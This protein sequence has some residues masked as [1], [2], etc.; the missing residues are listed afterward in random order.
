MQLSVILCAHNPRAE[1]L[2]RTLSSLRWQTVNA[3]RWDFV[4][5]DNASAKPLVSGGVKKLPEACNQGLEPEEVDLSWHPN[6]L[7]VRE[8]ELGL[9]P[10]RLRGIRESAGKVLVFVDDDNVLDADYL[11]QVCRIAGAYPHIGAWGGSCRGEF[12][13][14]PP[15]WLVPYLPG[16][17]VD[18][19]DRDYWSNLGSYGKASPYGAGLCVRSEVAQEF[20]RQVARRPNLKRLD[21][22]GEQLLSGGDTELANC[23][24]QL[25]LGTGRFSSLKLTHLIPK[26]RLTEDY[27]VKLYAGFEVSAAI[28]GQGTAQQKC[29][30]WSKW[31]R[32]LSWV[33]KWI[34]A[35]SLDR[36]IMCEVLRQM[37]KAGARSSKR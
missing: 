6:A 13:E 2:S 16:L 37:S 15:P 25:G 5:V 12:E 9:T 35:S 4:L 26:G 11:E 3:G 33:R 27:V 28:A 19:L 21:R 24:I 7:I 20:V 36:R 22:T 1:Y 34:F 17:V 29:P 30:F 10:A 8:E 18:E 23:S 32:G 14:E 31:P